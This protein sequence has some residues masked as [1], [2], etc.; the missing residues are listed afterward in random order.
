MFTETKYV[1][2]EKFYR[3]EKTLKDPI[4]KF[5]KLFYRCPKLGR[6]MSFNSQQNIL[7]S[8]FEI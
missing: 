4:M 3:I 1:Q 8:Y 2:N 7:D 6:M 5:K